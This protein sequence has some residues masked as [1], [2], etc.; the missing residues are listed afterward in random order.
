MRECSTESATDPAARRGRLTA[1]AAAAACLVVVASCAHPIPA[2]PALTPASPTVTKVADV[3]LNQPANV[4][5][6]SVADLYYVS[7]MGPGA[8]D[9]HDDNGFISQIAPDGHVVKLRWIAGGQQGAVLDAP[10]GMAIC[11][12][13]LVVADV[14]SVRLFDRKTGAWARSVNMPGVRLN[15]VACAPDGS[16]WV[17]DAGTAH[18]PAQDTTEDIDAVFRIG[19]DRSI[20][21]EARGRAL[22]RPEGIVIDSGAAVVATFAGNRL[23]RVP[24]R[25]L[26]ARPAATV[27]SAATAQQAGA[28]TRTGAAVTNAANRG[29]GANAGNRGGAAAGRAAGR[30][31]AGAGRAGR[32]AAAAPAAR[33]GPPPPPDSAHVV[34]TLPVGQVD[35]LRRLPDGSLIATSWEGHSVYRLGPNDQHY[36]IVT[37]I[38]SPSGV[39]VDTKRHRL[40]VTSTKGNML[41][42]VPLRTAQR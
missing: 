14:G 17:S 32:G 24:K 40:V 8:T 5:Y 38:T 16:L 39:A 29:R 35:A 26:T 37:G 27:A 33:R 13:T 9:K 28:T 20:V 3:G 42:L 22:Q 31:A 23:E 36:P 15:D 34:E 30:G 11:H 10:Q 2:P 7:N 12:D 19:V 1:G 18:E 41:Y 6:D 25:D 21:A 4:V